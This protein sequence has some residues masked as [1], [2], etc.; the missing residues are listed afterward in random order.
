L[1]HHGGC[2]VERREVD[3]SAR[4][5]HVA[6]IDLEQVVSLVF[7]RCRWIEIRFVAWDP[8]AVLVDEDEVLRIRGKTRL[9]DLT[10]GA[11]LPIEISARHEEASD[12]VRREPI[13]DG[14]CPIASLP[15]GQ[16]DVARQGR[17]QP[18][19]GRSRVE[20]TLVDDGEILVEHCDRRAT[21]IGADDRVPRRSIKRVER[22]SAEHTAAP[23]FTT[24]APVATD[25]AYA[26]DACATASARRRVAFTAAGDCQRDTDQKSECEFPFHLLP[27]ASAEEEQKQGAFN[28]GTVTM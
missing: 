19:V 3:A 14:K 24:S 20:P 27:P 26:T 11:H 12:D 9:T 10:V 8:C 25:A 21:E 4:R 1:G 16:D 28:R 13:D 2:R 17:N 18:R 5:A 15:A 7:G 22:R 6:R 23:A